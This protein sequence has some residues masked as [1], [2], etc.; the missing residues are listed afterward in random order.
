MRLEWEQIAALRK[1]NQSNP[2][3]REFRVRGALATTPVPVPR[4]Y[5]SCADK[6]VLG[7]A[8]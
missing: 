7:G 6:T 5:G 8:Y 4:V 3:F 2:T 1:S